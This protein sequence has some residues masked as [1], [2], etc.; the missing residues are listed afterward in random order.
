MQKKKPETKYKGTNNRYS[1]SF[2]GFPS[3][4]MLRTWMRFSTD[5]AQ[6]IIPTHLI[7]RGAPNRTPPILDKSIDNKKKTMP[8]ESNKGSRRFMGV[9]DTRFSRRRHLTEV[10]DVFEDGNIDGGF[11]WRYRFLTG[12]SPPE[13]CPALLTRKDDRTYLGL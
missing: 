4:K 13:I 6:S 9:P 5:N 10:R 1:I 8:H 11:E 3:L 7:P 2:D 12:N